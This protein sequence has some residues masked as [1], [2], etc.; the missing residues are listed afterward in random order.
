M[1]KNHLLMLI[2]FLSTA[3][4]NLLVQNVSAH[5]ASAAS[6]AST[7]DLYVPSLPSGVSGTANPTLQQ[8]DLYS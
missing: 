3:W 5:G 1:K 6:T 8:R 7:V 4:I 2:V